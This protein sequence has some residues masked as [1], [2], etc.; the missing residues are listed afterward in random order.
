MGRMGAARENQHVGGAFLLL[1][2]KEYKENHHT[3]FL[4]HKIC[5]LESEIFA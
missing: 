1:C 3:I 5:Y 2:S 4:T